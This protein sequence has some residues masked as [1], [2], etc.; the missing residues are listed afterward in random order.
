M[1]ANRL[2]DSRHPD[3][4]TQIHPE[5]VADIGTQTCEADMLPRHG[6]IAVV[7]HLLAPAT[8]G[9][10]FSLNQIRIPPKSKTLSISQKFKLCVIKQKQSQGPPW[11]SP[12]A[13]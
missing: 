4:H 10:E 9:T 11:P 6:H 12:T 7:T 8:S 5:M 13:N 2:S 3:V 1:Y